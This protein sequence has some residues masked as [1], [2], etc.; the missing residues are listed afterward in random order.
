[1]EEK[2]DLF[3]ERNIKVTNL[4][5]KVFHSFNEENIN[6]ICAFE[7]YGAMLAAGTD[8]ALYSSD[9]VD[10]YADVSLKQKS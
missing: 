5:A 4:I 7:N 10:L 8:I 1:M 9:D 2:Y 6:N 3:K